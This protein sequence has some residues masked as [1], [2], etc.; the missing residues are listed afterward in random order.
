MRWIIAFAAILIG[1]SSSI[2]LHVEA[3]TNAN[4]G[5]PVPVDIVFAATP[6]LEQQLITLSAQDWFTKRA[7][8]LRDYPDEDA[9][10]VVSFEF[11]PGQKIPEHKVRGNGA[12]MAIVFVNVGRSA[13]T[14]RARVPV[15]STV[16]LRLGEAAYSLDIV[17]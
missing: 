9:L 8:I 7:Q 3:D 10:K 4:F 16:H 2:Y 11:I 1:C 5:A 14:N 15:G 6:E 17:E 12:S 13:A